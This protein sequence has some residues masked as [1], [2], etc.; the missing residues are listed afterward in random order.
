MQLSLWTLVSRAF[1]AADWVIIR[2]LSGV[3]VASTKF[4][5]SDNETAFNISRLQGPEES[6]RG[7]STD[8]R[9]SAKTFPTCTRARE[10]RADLLAKEILEIADAPCKDAVEVAQSTVRCWARTRHSNLRMLSSISARAIKRC[11][12]QSASVHPPIRNDRQQFPG[13]LPPSGRHDMEASQ[14]SV[15]SGIFTSS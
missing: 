12:N 10:E 4:W 5:V 1:D 11:S 3:Q 9:D 13:S 2:T 15:P 14:T 8:N 7:S 6:F